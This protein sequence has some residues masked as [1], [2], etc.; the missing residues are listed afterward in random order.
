MQNTV[1]SR[2]DEHLSVLKRGVVDLIEELFRLSQQ[3]PSALKVL[4]QLFDAGVP[5]ISFA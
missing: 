2:V 5:V 4:L 1:S 3:L